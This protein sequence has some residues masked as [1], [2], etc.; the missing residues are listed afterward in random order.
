MRTSNGTVSTFWEKANVM[1]N[2]A[3]LRELEDCIHKQITGL[4][5][6]LQILN[7]PTRQSRENDLTKQSLVFEESRSS[8]ISV[9]DADASTLNRGEDGGRTTRAKS[10]IASLIPRFDFEGIL[11]TSQVYLRNHNRASRFT[12]LPPTAR[13]GGPLQRTGVAATERKDSRE[14]RQ[15]T[16]PSHQK[17]RDRNSGDD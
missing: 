16:R 8:V 6:V 10:T 12:N 14:Q 15:R 3:G 4:G 1:W 7:L 5:V 9:R 11:L 13:T 17:R 2:F